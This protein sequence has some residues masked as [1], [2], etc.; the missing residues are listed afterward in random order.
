MQMYEENF[1]CKDLH[2]TCMQMVW[3]EYVLAHNLQAQCYKFSLGTN[4]LHES[5]CFFNTKFV[6]PCAKNALRTFLSFIRKEKPK[7]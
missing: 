4:H 1:V 3:L 6:N 7:L 2:K 5:V